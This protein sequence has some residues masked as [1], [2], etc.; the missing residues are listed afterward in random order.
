VNI[1]SGRAVLGLFAAGD[2]LVFNQTDSGRIEIAGDYHPQKQSLVLLPAALLCSRASPNPPSSPLELV[3]G[4]DGG[5]HAGVGPAHSST[6][7]KAGVYLVL[8]M[9]RW[10]KDTNVGLM[11]GWSAASRS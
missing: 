4:S 8:R 10:W 2:S 5:A 7:V 9:R 11:V 6:M 1:E 3:A